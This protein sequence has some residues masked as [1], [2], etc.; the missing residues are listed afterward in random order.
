MTNNQG[1]PR[2]RPVGLGLEAPPSPRWQRRL[3]PLNASK[4]G[5]LQAALRTAR[6]THRARLPRFCVGLT[7]ALGLALS[8]SD[9]SPSERYPGSGNAGPVASGGLADVASGGAGDIG[10][11]AR[12]GWYLDSTEQT[13]GLRFL[14]QSFT[15]DSYTLGKLVFAH[16]GPNADHEAY[17]Y[18]LDYPED[19]VSAFC[20]KDAG[21]TGSF[22][23]CDGQT[24][25]D[26]AWLCCKA[27]AI[28]ELE[29]RSELADLCRLLPKGL[30]VAAAF[31]SSRAEQHLEPDRGYCS[32]SDQLA[33]LQ[34]ETA[35]FTDEEHWRTLYTGWLHSIH[36]LFERDYAGLPTWMSGDACRDKALQTGL[37]SWAELRHDTIL[38]V[39]QS[40]TSGIGGASSTLPPVDVNPY[41]VEPQPEVYSRLAD[42]TRLTR[43]GLGE[44]KM[45]ADALDRP[46]S[47]Q[48]TLLGRLTTISVAELHHEVIS[49]SDQDYVSGIGTTFSNT[50]VSIAAVTSEAPEP[51]DD[52]YPSTLVGILEGDPYKATVVADVHTDANTARV[53]EVGSGYVDWV[54]VVN[55]DPTGALVAN[56]GPIFSYYEFA[57]PMERRLNDNDW[58]ELLAS[59][60]APPR[61]AF[62]MDLYTQ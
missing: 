16:V 11:V 4:C 35:D 14:G 53:L 59:A 23:S 7:V 41:Y 8:C 26:W 33:S 50:I 30:D 9:E 62:L 44:L 51:P 10:S 18:V 48:E 37:T 38:Y 24:Q 58:A 45:L 54:V 42:L 22:A 5:T 43:H 46:I 25:A 40:Y 6:K 3:Q 55:L 36:P 61:P 17:Q 60:D 39:K 27:K 49:A 52:S 13:Q 12:G 32:C 29:G 1:V 47:N 57:Q 56:I 2:L 34:E 28:A 15:F 19:R 21:V 31:G 20:I